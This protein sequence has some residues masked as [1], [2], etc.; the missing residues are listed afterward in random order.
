MIKTI[1][2]VKGEERWTNRT[3]I[4]QFLKMP[5]P[6][7][8][9]KPKGYSSYAAAQWTLSQT[10]FGTYLE[11]KAVPIIHKEKL[12]LV[13]IKYIT[14]S[15]VVYFF[16]QDPQKFEVF[17]NNFENSTD[18][19]IQ[20][21]SNDY[22]SLTGLKARV[23]TL[24]LKR[25]YR[26]KY[27]LRVKNGE[28]HLVKIYN[29]SDSKEISSKVSV[30]TKISN[31]FEKEAKSIKPTTRKSNSEI[32]ADL[33]TLW[34]IMYEN[35]LIKKFDDS[36]LFFDVMSHMFKN[37]SEVDLINFRDYLN[38]RITLEQKDINKTFGDT[39]IHSINDYLTASAVIG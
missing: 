37:F 8:E 4:E 13:K 26:N 25:K 28:L 16:K 10:M 33:N 38:Y 27:F 29:P 3:I 34:T 7:V 23:N 18:T 32:F 20:I 12:Y 19:C 39:L 14:P 1:E 35:D 22:T 6:Y 17:L 2:M 30:E 36:G 24:L 9:I 31:F 11:K 15:K 21:K 5:D